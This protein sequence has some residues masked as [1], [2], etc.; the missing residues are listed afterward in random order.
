M[1]ISLKKDINP[2]GFITR[3][4]LQN[5]NVKKV[6]NSKIIVADL[7]SNEFKDLLKDPEVAFVEANSTVSIASLGEVG[8]DL[9]E[10]KSKRKQ[11][12]EIPWGIQAIGADLALKKHE[13]GKSIKIAILDKELSLILI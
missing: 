7:Q 13:D 5:K 9:A 11:A 8:Q 12:E 4:G 3:K 2:D 10:A 6:R 1:L